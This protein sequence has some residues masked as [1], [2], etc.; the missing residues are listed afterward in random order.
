MLKGI[1][2]PVDGKQATEHVL[3]LVEALAQQTGATI[4]LLFLAEASTPSSPLES[5]TPFRYEGI[6][7]T[8]W[9]WQRRLRERDAEYLVGLAERVGEEGETRVSTTLLVAPTA[10]E[11]HRLADAVEAELIVVAMAAPA[12]PRGWLDDVGFG[13][14]QRARLPLLLTPPPGDRGVRRTFE[15]VLVPLDGSTFSEQIIEQVVRLD[16]MRAAELV[17]LQ[18]LPVPERTSPSRSGLPLENHDLLS[19]Q[20]LARDYLRRVAAELKQRGVDASTRVM[21]HASTPDAI[22]QAAADHD[23]DMVAMATHG[24]GGLTRLLLG[25]VAEEVLRV[26]DRPLLL[27]RPREGMMVF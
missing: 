3:P 1:V 17:L 16:P 21:V 8:D 10:P 24:R 2:V 22:L 4:H 9:G 6:G 27:Y 12:E 23:V 15:R 7:A 13:M 14:L 20:G 19:R 11:V 5:F 26:T 25:S 18:V